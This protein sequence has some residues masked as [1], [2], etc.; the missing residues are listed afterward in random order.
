M[1]AGLAI[2]QG[3]KPT[4]PTSGRSANS[5]ANAAS[6]S[7][8]Q[9]QAEVKHYLTQMI[10]SQKRFYQQNQRLAKNLEEL[11]RSAAVVSHSYNY[12][13]RAAAQP[14]QFQLLA[15]AKTPEL[16]SYSA[17]VVLTSAETPAPIAASLCETNQPTQAPPIVNWTPGSDLKCPKGTTKV[18]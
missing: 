13:Y 1:V 4:Q 17:I 11:E 6:S 18:Q 16:K 9:Q 14:T 5:I 2:S 12:T 3:E 15:V 10:E 7:T 8:S